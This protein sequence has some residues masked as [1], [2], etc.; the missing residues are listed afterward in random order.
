MNQGDLPFAELRRYARNDGGVHGGSSAQ[1]PDARN[2]V[3]PDRHDDRV[4]RFLP[5]RLRRR[6]GV[7]QA[8]LP[9]VRPAGR[10]PAGV[11][12]LCGRLHRATLGRDRVRPF[13]RPH[14]A[15]EI[16]DVEPGDDGA[17]DAAD[18]LAAWLCQHRHLGAERGDA[19]RRGYWA[20]WPQAGVPLGSL[21]SA[22]ILALMAGFQ[23]EED[24]I[25]WGWR[26]PFLL[27]AVLVVVGW[28][29]RNRVA[30]S[31]MFAAEIEA[32]EAPPKL[33]IMDVVRERP[34][35]IL[36]GAG[37]RVG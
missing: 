10:D 4:V 5:L 8:V 24:F 27:S 20:S 35:G 25:A 12:N 36:L 2:R 14:R 30:E 16:A 7:Q 18:R 26:V 22:G 13:R 19:R 15:Q 11:R 17:R 37:L 29:I 32:A 9:F 31:P 28:Y 33:P 3:E 23:N 21:L 34:R 1:K 6:A